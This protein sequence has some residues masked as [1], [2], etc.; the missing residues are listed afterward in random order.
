MLPA[1]I[2]SEISL[3]MKAAILTIGDEILMGQITDTNSVYIARHLSESGIETCRMQSVPD[4]SDAIR[5]ALDGLL[6]EADLLFITGGLGPTKDD[7]TKKILCDYFDDEL[8]FDDQTFRHIESL[9]ANRQAPMNRLNRDQALVPRKA[10]ILPNRKGTAAGMWFSRNGKQAVSLPGVPFEMECLMEEEVMPRLHRRFPQIAMAYRMFIVYN[11]A[12]GTVEARKYWRTGGAIG[13]EKR[14]TRENRDTTV[15]LPRWG[16]QRFRRNVLSGRTFTDPRTWRAYYVGVYAGYEKYTIS[17]GRNGKQGDSYNFGFTGGWSIPVYPFRDG[18]SLDLDLG[19]A[20]GAKM[21]AY[22]EFGYDEEYGCYTYK[23]TRGRHF[24]PYPVVQDIHLTFI[25]RFRSISKKVQGGAERYSEWDTRQSE[26]RAER[27]RVR[28]RNWQLRDS[29]RTVS[30]KARE[31]EELHRDSV[32][33]ALQVADSLKDLARQK[34]KEMQKTEADRDSRRARRKAERAAKAEERQAGD[35]REQ[36]TPQAAE[37]ADNRAAGDGGR[38]S[39]KEKRRQKK[40]QSQEAGK[41]AGV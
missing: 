20:V 22:D 14:Y 26:K 3:S 10:E 9:L 40:E 39:R 38:K 32:R 28:Q 29:M 36:A 24:V 8:V 11:V 19:L 13:P 17:L 27:T 21:T 23:G 25:F 41:E 34:E 37:A 30:R 6:A 5:Q 31:L 18:R 35:A 15:S 4:Q 1:S 7:I 2:Q 16:F 33:K 12:G